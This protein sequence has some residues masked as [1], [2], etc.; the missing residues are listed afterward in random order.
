M[1]AVLFASYAFKAS[2]LRLQPWRYVYEM[3]KRLPGLGFPTTIA[4]DSPLKGAH[5]T[6]GVEVSHGFPLS[7]FAR[8]AARKAVEGV[9]PDIIL[10][11]LGPKS[12]A[13]VPMFRSFNARIIGYL[14]GPIGDFDDLYAVCRAKIPSEGLS[15]ASWPAARWLRWGKIMESV[16]ERFIVLSEENRKAMAKMGIDESRIHVVTAGRDPLK[17]G[18]HCVEGNGP[19]TDTPPSPLRKKT[20]LFMGWPTKL[21]GIELLLNAFSMAAP[22]SGLLHLKILARGDGS[23]DHLR[24]RRLVG[25]HSARDRISLIDGFLAKEKVLEHIFSCHFGV[26]PFIFVPADRPLSFL[27]FFAAG[28]PVVSTDASGIS[29]LIGADRGLISARTS[30]YSLAFNLVR[31]ANMSES[32]YAGYGKACSDFIDKYPDWDECA[33]KLSKVLKQ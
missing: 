8:G 31:M 19:K 30:P 4:T 29:E 14:P 20:V 33:L 15:A 6:P 11:P 13:Y 27:E 3:A 7:P 23:P 10:W 9:A 5:L 16:C 22:R 17:E 1:S 12:I 26:L 28:K 25:K 32:E 24:L 21:R 2:N 18:V